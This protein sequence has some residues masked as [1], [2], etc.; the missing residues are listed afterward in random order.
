VLKRV[1]TL[2]LLAPDPKFRQTILDDAD[3][4]YEQAREFWDAGG[5]P[6][7]EL[8]AN[9]PIQTNLRIRVIASTDDP[10]AVWEGNAGLLKRNL[11]QMQYT[12]YKWMN[13]VVKQTTKTEW[14][15]LKLDPC[16]ARGDHWIHAQLFTNWSRRTK[17][18]R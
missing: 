14:G 16:E 8:C 9:L 3:S 5:C 7:D 10:V 13:A 6:G 17:K 15:R 11:G 4:A 1:V 2:C 18:G 12:D